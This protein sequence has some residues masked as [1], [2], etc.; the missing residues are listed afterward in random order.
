MRCSSMVRSEAP[1]RANRSQ[2]ASSY[3]SKGTG[4]AASVDTGLLDS[5]HHEGGFVV[6]R[7]EM[8]VT[9]LWNT[10]YV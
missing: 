2:T 3:A 1:P 9:T 8:V 6:K 10:P 7:T 4:V 5:G